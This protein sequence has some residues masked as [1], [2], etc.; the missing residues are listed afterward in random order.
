MPHCIIHN[1]NKAVG[2]DIF[3]SFSNLGTCRPE[4]AGVVISGVAFDSISTDVH[5]SFGDYRL[6]RGRIIRLFVRPDPFRALF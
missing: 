3:G 4:V 5:A 6:H 1:A 2:C